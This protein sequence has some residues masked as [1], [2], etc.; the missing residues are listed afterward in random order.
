MK[1]KK[2]WLFTS[3]SD[4][5][6]I[7]GA[8]AMGYF[9]D[10][11]ILKVA[12]ESLCSDDNSTVRA[13]ADFSALWHGFHCD[14]IWHGHGLWAESGTPPPGSCLSVQPWAKQRQYHW[15][16]SVLLHYL[17]EFRTSCKNYFTL[18]NLINKHLPPETRCSTILWSVH[19]S[20]LAR[21]LSYLSRNATGTP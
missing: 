5:T 6:S 16:R 19:H 15:C 9:Y 3:F 21:D 13:V 8:I 4:P 20:S 11:T 1:K 14:S 10:C 7:Y 17:N 2:E 18:V 12:E